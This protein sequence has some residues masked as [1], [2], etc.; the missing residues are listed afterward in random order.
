MI[1]CSVPLC[2]AD[3][4][5]HDCF[6]RWHDAPILRAENERLGTALRLAAG[7]IST[8]PQKEHEH[9]ESVHDWLLEEADKLLEVSDDTA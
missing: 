4:L 7:M 9:P 5:C 6:A 8:M 1:R 2:S 3:G